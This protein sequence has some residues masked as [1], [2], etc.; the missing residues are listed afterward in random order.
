MP[1]G[2]PTSYGYMGY[3]HDRWM[4]F[5]TQ[6]EYLEYIRM[7]FATQQEYPEYIREEKDGTD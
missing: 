4:V 6:H 7:V 5:A 3:V 2:Y 1:K